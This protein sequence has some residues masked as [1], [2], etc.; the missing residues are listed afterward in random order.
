MRKYNNLFFFVHVLTSVSLFESCECIYWLWKSSR[1]IWIFWS[2]FLW[3]TCNFLYFE[4]WVAT[5]LLLVCEPW[6]MWNILSNGEHHHET[7]FSNVSFLACFVFRIIKFQL[8]TKRI[9]SIVD[10]ITSFHWCRLGSNN[11]VHFVMKCKE[12][13][14]N[15]N[16]GCL[17]SKKLFLFN[18]LTHEKSFDWQEQDHYWKGRT[19]W[20]ECITSIF[21]NNI[22]CL[23]FL[24]QTKNEV[25]Q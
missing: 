20:K 25:F 23:F 12:L 16:E 6:K 9:F 3:W 19:L 21:A 8:E 10:V 18:F 17:G 24:W 13:A 22:S 4:K 15:V 14:N 5:I 2:T 1:W 7:Q 11:L